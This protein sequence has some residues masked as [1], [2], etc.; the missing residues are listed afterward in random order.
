MRALALLACLAAAPAVAAGQVTAF[1]P[2]DEA[3]E[4]PSFLAF[5]DSMMAALAADDTTWIFRR[6][7]PEVF[8]G[9]GGSGGVEELRTVYWNDA[10]RAELATALCL[11]GHMEEGP[12]RT[13]KADAQFVAPYTWRLPEPPPGTDEFDWVF[14]TGAVLERGT[15]VVSRPGGQVL[16]M[17]GQVLVPVPDWWPPVN[18]PALPLPAWVEVRLADGRTGYARADRIRSPVDLR[19]FFEKRD[20]VWWWAGWAAGD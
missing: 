4:D 5:R 17:L 13:G 12:G 14:Q 9:F 18:D 11:G 16:A 15:P 19:L 2:V 10:F 1:P 7:I 6:T 20:G 8:N 3:E